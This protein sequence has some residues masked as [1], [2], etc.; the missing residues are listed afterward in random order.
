MHTRRC[1]AGILPFTRPPASFYPSGFCWAAFFVHSFILF[2]ILTTFRVSPRNRTSCVILD[3]SF[4]KNRI[5]RESNRLLYDS[6]YSVSLNPRAAYFRF[7]FQAR[8]PPPILCTPRPPA[9][10]E[11]ITCQRVVEFLHAPPRNPPHP[12]HR[13]DSSHSP[14]SRHREGC[15]RH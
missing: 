11:H 12:V 13:R 14:S 3:P 8:P 10:A 9:Q 7:F 4:F 2:S 5:H 1:A 6:L 15:T